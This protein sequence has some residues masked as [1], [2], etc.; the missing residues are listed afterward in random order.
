M[1]RQGMSSPS[2]PHEN[3]PPRSI[4]ARFAIT[5]IAYMSELN[6]EIRALR[7][8]L[9]MSQEELASRLGVSFATVNRWESGKSKPQRAQR[10]AL[11]ALM[12][13]HGLAPGEVPTAGT[14]AVS[15]PGRR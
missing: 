15:S 11:D 2:N 3:Y 5:Y 4:D 6:A 10:A 12:G 1:E 7:T 8:T 14:S 9:N 13:E